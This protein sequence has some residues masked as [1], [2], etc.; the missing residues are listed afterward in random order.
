MRPLNSHPGTPSLECSEDAPSWDVPSVNI[1]LKPGRGHSWRRSESVYRTW[2]PTSVCQLTGN[3]TQIPKTGSSYSQ[4]GHPP[5]SEERGESQV[6]SDH[7]SLDGMDLSP[8]QG[9]SS[10]AGSIVKSEVLS[11]ALNRKA[12]N[13]SQGSMCVVTEAGSKSF[14][15]VVECHDG[16]KRFQCDAKQLQADTLMRFKMMSYVD[17]KLRTKKGGR[18]LKDEATPLRQS[19]Q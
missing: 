6:Q 3:N 10:V 2:Y 15:N 8:S 18:F 19:F 16:N 11:K 5:E 9:S 7:P 12:L 14:D 1:G 17:R 13:P 4:G